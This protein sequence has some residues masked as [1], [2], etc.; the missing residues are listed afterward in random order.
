M[1]EARGVSKLTDAARNQRCTVRLPC[2]SGDPATTV[3]AH[4]R[5]VRLGA[6]TAHKPHDLIGAWACNRCHDE[7]DRRTRKYP[8][9]EVRAAHLEGCLE[10]IDLLV[11]LGKVK[12]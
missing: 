5:S 10:T 9:E 3:L 4:Y 12:V 1:H 8:Y 6:G 7:C 2:C 11:R